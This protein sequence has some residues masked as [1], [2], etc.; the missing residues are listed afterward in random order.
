V[1]LGLVDGFNPCAMWVLLFLLSLLV[2][3]RSRARIALVAGTFV[4]VSGLVYFAF[5]AAW[6]EVYFFIG[7]SRALQIA[8]GTLALLIGPCT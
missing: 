8:L 7:Y 1:L 5:M 4:A 6:L 3:V 2:H